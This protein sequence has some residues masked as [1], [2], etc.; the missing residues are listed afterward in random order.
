MNLTKNQTLILC[1]V[2]AAFAMIERF[3][4]HMPNATPI[5]AIAFAGSFYLGRRAAFL[6]LLALA[7]SDLTIGWYDWPVML[8]VYGSVAAISLLAVAMKKYQGTLIPWAAV[9]SSSVFFYLTTNFAVWATSVWY[10]KTL[11]GLMM[12]YELGLPFLRNMMVGDLAY[13]ALLFGAFELAR[14]GVR[15]YRLRTA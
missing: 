7:I 5:T 2:L 13:T 15:Q 3:V 9:V 1:A 8:T 4:P 10:P 12:S 6:P 14:Y 11:A